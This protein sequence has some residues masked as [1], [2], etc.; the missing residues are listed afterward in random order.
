MARHN[1]V[2]K[3]GEDIAVKHLVKQGFK[4]LER[5]YR[6]KWGEI[7]IIAIKKGLLHFVEVKTVSYETDFDNYI[8]EENVNFSK[9]KKLTRAINTYLAEKRV[10]Y[11]TEFVVDVV[12][13]YFDFFTKN[14]KIRVLENVIL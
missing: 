12:A 3:I 10:S 6:K 7:D 2:G 4:I 14:S 5:N 8:P 11:E 13:V 9:R 1:E